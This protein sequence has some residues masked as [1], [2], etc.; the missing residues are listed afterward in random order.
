MSHLNDVLPLASEQRP[1]F[2][3]RI[4]V[5]EL[6]KE[7]VRGFPVAAGLY[8]SQQLVAAPL[9]HWLTIR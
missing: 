9:I 7:L 6:R 4:T 3:N 5:E 1:E 2:L 8:L